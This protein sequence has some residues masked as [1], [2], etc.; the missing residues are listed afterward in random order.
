[1]HDHLYLRD[2]YFSVSVI[3]PNTLLNPKLVTYATLAA[4]RA[5]MLA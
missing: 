4:V 2:S 3:P 1:M 5:L